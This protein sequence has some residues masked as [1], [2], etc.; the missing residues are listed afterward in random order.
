MGNPSDILVV[1]REFCPVIANTENIL[2]KYHGKIIGN[3]P[4]GIF[5]IL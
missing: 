1:N 5:P 3:Y 4:K 2:F